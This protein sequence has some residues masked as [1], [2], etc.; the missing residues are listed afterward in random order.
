MR[1]TLCFLTVLVGVLLTA[2]SALAGGPVDLITNGGFE[3]GFTGWTDSTT[4]SNP[5]CA[6]SIDNCGFD[7]P[8]ADGGAHYASNGFDGN[9][10][11]TYTL[12]QTVAIPSGTA[13][14][15]W[16]D[17]FWTSYFGASRV[18][19]VEIL[20]ASGTTTLGTVYSY[21][22]PSNAFTGWV[23][24]SVDVSAF[25]GQTVQVAFVQVIPGNFTGPAAMS[26]DNVQ[27]LADP[28]AGARVGYCSAP[29]DTW[30]DGTPMRSGTFLDLLAGQP[31]TDPHYAGATVAIM[32]EGL[33]ITCDA[34]PAGYTKRGVTD[35]YANFAP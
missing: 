8:A 28:V 31:S 34:P 32:V 4:L 15:S 7:P 14:L 17:D 23:Q 16:E 26:I 25:A 9:G 11:G 35:P 22:A 13:T 27:L 3:N 12:A 18:A 6:W 33:G 2:G 5:L 24:H 29:G 20:D 10:P 1:R 30:Q 21:T 19:E